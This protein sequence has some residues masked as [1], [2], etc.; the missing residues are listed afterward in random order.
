VQ[1]GDQPAFVL[2]VRHDACNQQLQ[3][4]VVH[5]NGLALLIRSFA[6]KKTIRDWHLYFGTFIFHQDK[7]SKALNQSF[8]RRYFSG[9][10]GSLRVISIFS[11][12]L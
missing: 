3:V 5:P 10:D 9:R 1:V 6:I 8:Q 2:A 11:A 7:S 4:F 12:S